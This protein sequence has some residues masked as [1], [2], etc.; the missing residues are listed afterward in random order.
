MR[1][2]RKPAI[3]NI[4]I[5]IR[6]SQEDDKEKSE[7]NSVTNQKKLLL[8]YINQLDDLVC[9]IYSLMMAIPT[10]TLIDQLFKEPLDINERPEV[11]KFLENRFLR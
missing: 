4:A 6:L 10:V 11:K 3:F 5:Y 9:M 2:R 8:D 7:S 1:S